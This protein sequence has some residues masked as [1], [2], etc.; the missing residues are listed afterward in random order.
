MWC[1]DLSFSGLEGFMPPVT[2]FP[3]TLME[4]RLDNNRIR[5]TLPDDWSSLDQLQDLNLAENRLSGSTPAKLP[6]SLRRLTL[7]FNVLESMSAV[8]DGLEELDVG[9]NGMKSALPPLPAS[10]KLF[11]GNNNK[12]KGPIP[13]LPANITLFSAREN[14][15]TGGLPANL[16]PGLTFFLVDNNVLIG[17]IPG[18][19]SR[20]T[21]ESEDIMIRLHNNSLTGDWLPL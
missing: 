12:F 18:T 16:P 1:R 15:L 10:L 8:N 4:L 9:Y 13:P 19:W 5:G 11:V 20:P 21:I 7:S 2:S 17:T 14:V 6:T 3:G